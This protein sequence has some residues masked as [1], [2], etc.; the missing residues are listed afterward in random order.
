MKKIITGIIIIGLAYGGY[1][2]F[3][4]KSSTASNFTYINTTVKKGNIENSVEVIGTSQL[5]HEQKMRFNQTGKV[6]KIFFKE[7]EKIQQGKIIAELDTTDVLSDIKQQELSLN[8][9]QIK[10]AQTIK[11]AEAKDL[12]NAQNTITSTKSKI[13]TLEN[14]RVNILRDQANKQTDY[15]SQTTAKQNDIKSNENDIKNKQAQL[16]NMKNEL[17]TLEKTEDK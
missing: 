3:F 8:N 14:D 7:G 6:A 15:A 9:A 17:V 4:K 12:L 2:Y 10:L 11:G 13:T 16:A 1:V 5:V